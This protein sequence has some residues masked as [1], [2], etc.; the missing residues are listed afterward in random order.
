ML[1]CMNEVRLSFAEVR[2]QMSL[3]YQIEITDNTQ[4]KRWK[5]HDTEF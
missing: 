2:P 1:S 3:L 4:T 5:H